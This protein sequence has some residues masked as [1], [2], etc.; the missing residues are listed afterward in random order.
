[1]QA[2]TFFEM[3]RKRGFFTTLSKLS[4]TPILRTQFFY[5]IKKG[6]YLNEFFRVKD[7]LVAYGLIAFSLTPA[8]E[9]LIAL[10]PRGLELRERIEQVDLILSN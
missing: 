5:E 7:D 3:F 8:G 10:T 2:K 4:L 1:M 9:Y 6:G